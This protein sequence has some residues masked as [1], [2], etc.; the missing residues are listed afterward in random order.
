MSPV[1]CH[2]YR[3]PFIEEV[4]QAAVYAIE[5]LRVAENDEN[6][7]IWVF[8]ELIYVFKWLE[9][10]PFQKKSESMIP[11]LERDSRGLSGSATRKQ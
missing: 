1:S 2:Q 7:V 6:G 9:V 4:F 11:L 8:I 10:V 3:A 5:N